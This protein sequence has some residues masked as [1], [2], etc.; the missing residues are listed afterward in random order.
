MSATRTS[1]SCSYSKTVTITFVVITYQVGFFC[2][3]FGV[4]P[5]ARPCR[6]MFLF[7]AHRSRR[8]QNR[9]HLSSPDVFY[10]RCPAQDGRDSRLLP[11]LELVRQTHIPG[12]SRAA[13][14]TQQKPPTT[15]MPISDVY[16]RGRYDLFIHRHLG[17]QNGIGSQRFK[18][19]N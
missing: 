5:Q 2:H 19:S 15:T 4:K 17:D 12:Q 6:R 9:R 3:K 13:L 11:R 16:N 1:L 10:L 7:L 14:R 8:L 18:M